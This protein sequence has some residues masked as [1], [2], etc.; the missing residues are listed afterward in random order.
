MPGRGRM[1]AGRV[2]LRPRRRV[3]EHQR[4]LRL[5]L[6]GGLHGRRILL[7]GL[8]GLKRKTKTLESS[9]FVVTSKKYFKCHIQKQQ[10]QT[11]ITLLVNFCKKIMGFSI[12]TLDMFLI[13]IFELNNF[14]KCKN[15]EI[16]ENNT[17]NPSSNPP[18]V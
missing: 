12:V 18:L 17:T 15:N 6:Q 13:I 9:N 8:S 14:L 2:P 11:F 5:H 4:L 1:R 16:G 7:P 3:Q 10:D